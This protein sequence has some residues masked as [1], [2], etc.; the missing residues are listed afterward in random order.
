L[1]K[2]WFLTFL[3][4]C[5][6]CRVRNAGRQRVNRLVYC[7][8]SVFRLARLLQSTMGQGLRGQL[9]KNIDG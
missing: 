5:N 2:D 7:I 9:S 6:F 3:K 8:Y 4:R 1:V